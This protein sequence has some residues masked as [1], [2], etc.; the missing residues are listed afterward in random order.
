MELL[1]LLL[2]VGL[3]VGIFVLNDAAGKS[4]GKKHR[5]PRCGNTGMHPDGGGY[6]R[7]GVRGTDWNCPHCGHRFFE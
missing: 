3:G 2:I 6:Y 1:G 7:N 4:L 5:C